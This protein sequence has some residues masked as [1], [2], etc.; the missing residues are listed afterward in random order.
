MVSDLIYRLKSR[1]KPDLRGYKLGLF[2]IKSITGLPRRE[3][4]SGKRR[5]MFS[6]GRKGSKNSA[7]KLVLFKPSISN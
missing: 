4:W 3:Q 1:L 5:C 6:S 2:F 7:L